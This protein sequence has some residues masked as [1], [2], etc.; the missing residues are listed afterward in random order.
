MHTFFR[1]FLSTDAYRRMQIY[2]SM[3]KLNSFDRALTIAFISDLCLLLDLETSVSYLST[4]ILYR[5]VTSFKFKFK[6]WLTRSTQNTCVYTCLRHLFKH[7]Y[8]VNHM[9]ILTA[10]SII[11]TYLNLPQHSFTHPVCPT[12]P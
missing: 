2:V 5:E 4:S 3:K 6:L 7:L 1:H 12:E 10:G 9:Y 11:V 8:K